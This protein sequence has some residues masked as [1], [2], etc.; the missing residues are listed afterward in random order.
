MATTSIP[1]QGE[2]CSPIADV[3]DELY[4]L[5]VEL[6][7]GVALAPQF[8]AGAIPTASE[9]IS[10]LLG[11]LFSS[12]TPLVPIFK[13]IECVLAVFE[14]IKAIPQAILTLNPQ[15][16]IEA[17]AKL[18][19]CIDFLIKLI[20][21][22]S[23]PVMIKTIID[24][25]VVGLQAIKEQLQN[26]QEVQV[27]LDL[28]ALIVDSL[29]ENFPVGA[30]ELQQSLDCA[31]Y[32]FDLEQQATQRSMCP[33]NTLLKL[34]TLFL[35]LLGLPAIGP[36]DISGELQPAIDAVDAAIQVLAGLKQ[37]IPGVPTVAG[38]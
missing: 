12:L 26:L 20:P 7:A 25:L 5:V 32:N 13:I 27:D 11:Q 37:S 6:P 2:L 17:V 3:L 4:A 29:M 24:V 8:V 15:K 1:D 30:S 23:V 33:F 9:A 16:L 34:L 18:A 10:K 19:K 22:L 28:K 14:C 31:L 38:C 36:F 21:Q 35:D